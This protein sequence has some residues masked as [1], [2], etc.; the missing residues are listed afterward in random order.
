[1]VKTPTPKKNSEMKVWRS[2]VILPYIIRSQPG[3]YQYTNDLLC[4]SRLMGNS[5]TKA[6]TFKY[7]YK[8]MIYRLQV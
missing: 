5:E 1:M 2:I 6:R 4:I 3:S 8:Y 7:F